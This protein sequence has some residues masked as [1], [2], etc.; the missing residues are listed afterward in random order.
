MQAAMRVKLRVVID[1]DLLC[2]QTRQDNVLG[3]LTGQDV[4]GSSSLRP[5]IS[6]VGQHT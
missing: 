6:I 1:V 4:S 2:R 5:S 3:G